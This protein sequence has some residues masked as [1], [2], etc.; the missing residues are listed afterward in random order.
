MLAYR[1][2][3]IARC[4][5]IRDML[6]RLF[7]LLLI[8]AFLLACADNPLVTSEPPTPIITAI[9]TEP[10]TPTPL[11]SPEQAARDFLGAWDKGQYE[12]MYA[13]VSESARQSVSQEAFVKRYR[14]IAA[15]G[16]F[17]AVKTQV[18]EIDQALNKAVVK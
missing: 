18:K 7:I 2:L 4:D 13:L 1:L 6:K 8:F 14:D 5:A 9:P 3:H 10:A 15:E 16:A 11:P 12:V 17:T